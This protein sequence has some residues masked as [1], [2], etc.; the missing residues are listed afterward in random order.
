[1]FSHLTIGT[2]D[3]ARAI[4]FY[5]AILAPLGMERARPALEDAAL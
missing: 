5:D 3:F 1:M 2:N 4:G